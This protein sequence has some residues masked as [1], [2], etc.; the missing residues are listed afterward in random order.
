[1][2]KK[3]VVE[4]FG[5]FRDLT[6]AGFAGTS[7][8]VTFYGPNGGSSAGNAGITVQTARS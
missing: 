3:P 8:G 4:R 6:L 2:Y 7:D 5:S 1:M